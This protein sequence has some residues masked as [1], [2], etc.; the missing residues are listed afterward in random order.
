MSTDTKTPSSLK[1]RAKSLASSP[2][3]IAILIA[4]VLI[5]LSFVE[6]VTGSTDISSPG[7]SGATLRFAIPL[8]MAGLGG[9]WA[10]R[11]GVINI[12]LEGM[13]IVGTWTGAWFGFKHGP[14]V[15]FIAAAVFGLLS[16]LFHAIL[17]VKIGID[18]AVSGL[19][20]NLIA[21]GGARYLS[22][23]F[24]PPVGGDRTVSPPVASFPTFTLP[25]VS[26]FL[27]KIDGKNIFFISNVAGMLNGFTKEMSLVTLLFLFMVPLT[28]WILWRSKFGLR[29][30]FSGENPMAAESL[31][32]NVYRIRY[33]AV[34]VSGMLASLGGAYLAL[35]ASSVYRE[36]QTAGRG[37]IGLATVIFG[38]WKP[39][40]VFAG[41]ML[42]GFTDALRVR[43]NKSVMAL[44]LVAG[45]V[46]AFLAIYFAFKKK[47]KPAIYAFVVAA[48][49][50][51]LNKTVEVIPQ[52]FVT[53]FP[54]FA[55]LIVLTFLAQRLTPPAAAGA[56]YRRGSE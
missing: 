34:S 29:M 35:V 12:G 39:G 5:I 8:L 30:R 31:G 49:A 37:F 50:L 22:G 24:F 9:L 6:K 20:I 46:A 18:Q 19:A 17:T 21:A 56:P 16:G 4:G 11:A 53:V 10:E 28:S 38:N 23:I 54:N 45:I 25:G 48:L 41:S 15:G 36:G 32:I 27:E 52:E 13:M 44:I 51:L 42:F 3:R 40:G 2:T 33:V 26:P 43:E 47:W 55:T 1:S 14:L 7:T